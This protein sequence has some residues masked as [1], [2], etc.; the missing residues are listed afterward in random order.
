[1]VREAAV[2]VPVY[3]R[4][5]GQL[6]V[7]L[8]RRAQGGAH[9]GQLALPGG[10]RDPADADLAATALR[11]ANE[12]LGLAADQLELLAALPVVATRTTGFRIAPFLARLPGPVPWRLQER[13]IAEV[14]EVPVA[15]LAR[16][17]ARAEAVRGFPT[18]PAPRR[19]QLW[20][21]GRHEVW[22][23][24]YRILEPLVPR[25]LGGEWPL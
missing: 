3:R 11:E 6:V 21:V 22:G 1:M 2:L 5:D 4:P 23:M 10:Q 16:P 24:T 20:R 13:E 12:E 8:V 15:A 14:V 25:L 17:E 9:G 19:V 7:V 18:W